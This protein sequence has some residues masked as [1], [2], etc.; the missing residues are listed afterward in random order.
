MTISDAIHEIER[1]DPR[2]LHGHPERMAAEIVR[3]Q[4]RIRQLEVRVDALV[5]NNPQLFGVTCP[6]QHD[7][8]PSR[9]P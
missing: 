5:L 3:L 9:N 8:Q 4:E 6:E 7:D 2:D 1:L